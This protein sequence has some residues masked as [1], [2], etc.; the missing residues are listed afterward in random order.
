MSKIV[1]FN[2]HFEEYDVLPVCQY[3]VCSDCKERITRYPNGRNFYQILFVLR[4][5]GFLEMKGKT[6]NLKK[7]NAF[8]IGEGVPQY[9]D[10]TDNLYTAFLTARGSGLKLLQEYY[11]CDG[12]LWRD[13]VDK[14]V[15]MPYI[16]DIENELAGES[17]NPVLSALTY[18]A[19]VNFFELGTGNYDKITSVHQYIEKNFYQKIS[20]DELA[21][22]FEI[23][24][25]SLS[26]KFKDKYGSSI[27]ECI[28]DIRLTYARNMVIF[29]PDFQIK[30]V[31]LRCGFDDFS[32]FSKAY[33]KKFGKTPMEEK[34]NSI[35]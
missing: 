26:H 10:T 34:R 24:V 13:F 12:F 7:G 1:L 31:A 19:F 5:S 6:Y 3:T 28:M 35:L 17:R 32:Y 11:N 33:K 25:S 21:Q 15:Y 16:C 30:D 18:R 4:G 22:K 23:S 27:F 20:L 2:R 29:N 14:S 8:Y 9:Y